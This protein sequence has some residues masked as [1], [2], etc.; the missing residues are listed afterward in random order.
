MAERPGGRRPTTVWTPRPYG[1][2]GLSRAV[3]SDV[4][5]HR[6]RACR[7]ERVARRTAPAPSGPGRSAVVAIEPAPPA[8]VTTEV[9]GTTEVPSD[10]SIAG[11][12]GSVPRKR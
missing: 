8:A 2:R 9:N 6:V 3:R 4:G 12:F 11:S 7:L 10:R 5:D 1:M